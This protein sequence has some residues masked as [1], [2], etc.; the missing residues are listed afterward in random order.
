MHPQAGIPSRERSVSNLS[1]EGNPAEAKLRP[2]PRRSGHGRA[3]AERSP[4]SSG[5]DLRA[6][7]LMDQG[8]HETRRDQSSSYASLN[9]S[10]RSRP[11]IPASRVPNPDPRLLLP[12]SRIPNPESRIPNPASRLRGRSRFSAAKARLPRFPP[13]APCMFSPSGLCS[14]KPPDLSQLHTRGQAARI[15]LVTS[16][17]TKPNSARPNERKHCVYSALWRNAHSA[18][19]PAKPNSRLSR[20]GLRTSARDLL[21][22]CTRRVP[23]FHHGWVQHQ[24]LPTCS[25]PFLRPCHPL[26]PSVLAS[27]SRDASRWP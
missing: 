6:K 20:D 11:P 23:R 13:G 17:G 24:P 18:A 19:N 16:V 26:A 12:A 1:R 21:V 27:E 5:H 14:S 9:L 25:L 15:G 10:P 4:R 8:I 3:Q 2:L 7:E 22:P